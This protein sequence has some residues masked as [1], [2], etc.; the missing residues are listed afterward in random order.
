MKYVDVLN[1]CQSLPDVQKHYSSGSCNA[2]SLKVANEPFAYFE[3]GAPIQ[4]QFVVRVT[5]ALFVEESAPLAAA[6][7]VK[8]WARQF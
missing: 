4:W 7:W 5:A 2:F 6:L 3:T 8:E 1:Y